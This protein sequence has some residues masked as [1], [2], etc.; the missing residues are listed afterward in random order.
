M[1]YKLKLIIFILFTVF[2]ISFNAACSTVE[3]T[4]PAVVVV[5]EESN[6]PTIQLTPSVNNE[7]GY[8]VL[9]AQTHEPGYPVTNPLTENTL[10]EPPNPERTLPLAQQDSGVLGGV[11]IWEVTESGFLPLEPKDLIL[12]EV[13]LNSNNEPAYIRDNAESPKAQLFPTGIFIFDAVPPG[14][15]G[16]VVDVGYTKFPITSENEDVMIIDIIAGEVLD[17]GQIITPLPS[18]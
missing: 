16:L 1:H 18:S 12:A 11:L 14:Q 13:I 10:L 4:A 8:P 6:T 9:V 2:A 15:Y 5:T 17:L 7:T 3:N